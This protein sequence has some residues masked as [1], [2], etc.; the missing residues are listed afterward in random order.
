MSPR[1]NK[2][3]SAASGEFSL[4]CETDENVRSYP[5]GKGKG[6]SWAEVGG[7]LL[8]DGKLRSADELPGIWPGEAEESER[9]RD[10]SRAEAREDEP[11]T[12]VGTMPFIEG[13][14]TCDTF[15]D[16]VV[17]LGEDTR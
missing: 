12:Y 4:L 5:G 15:V 7:P 8:L 1:T 11:I 9:L 2:C 10:P 17:A 14:D 13:E 6:F 3:G 16:A